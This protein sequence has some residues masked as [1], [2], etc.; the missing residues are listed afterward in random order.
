MEKKGCGQGGGGAGSNHIGHV[1]FQ[2]NGNE[3][4]WWRRREGGGINVFR[5]TKQN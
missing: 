2:K 3:K 5:R 4:S 1:A